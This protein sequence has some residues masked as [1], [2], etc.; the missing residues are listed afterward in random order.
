M[1]AVETNTFLLSWGREVEA[2]NTGLSTTFDNV[3]RNINKIKG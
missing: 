1:E 3:P 2:G